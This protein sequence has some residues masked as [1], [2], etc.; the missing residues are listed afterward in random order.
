MR[1]L[2]IS[3]FLDSIHTMKKVIVG[4]LFLVIIVGAFLFLRAKNMPQ[5]HIPSIEGTL[6]INETRFLS[7]TFEIQAP[8]SASVFRV[9]HDREVRV[10]NDLHQSETREEFSY[11][12]TAEEVQS[13]LSFI[14]QNKILDL[15][16]APA[17]ATS[18][19]DGSIYTLTVS[20][21]SES[22]GGDAWVRTVQ[23]YQYECDASVIE[24]RRL[25]QEMPIGKDLLEIGV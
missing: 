18:Q 21:D 2:F 16:D 3:S 20:G 10:V 25:I 17:T 14:E 6:S 24:L 22:T 13:I 1:V 4:V 9:A 8:F 5:S 19:T 11:T 23:C 15:P 12:G 7:L